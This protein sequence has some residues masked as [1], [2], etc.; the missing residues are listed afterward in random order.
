MTKPNVYIIEKGS[1]GAPEP[2]AELGEGAYSCVTT[3]GL[4]EY[5]KK[6]EKKFMLVDSGMASSFDKI[7]DEI[8]KHGKL[9]D[10]THILMTH[11]DQDH[12][13]NNN[14]FPGA[15]IISAV[16]TARSG[17]CTFGSIESLYPDNYIENENISYVD[18]SKTHSR[19]EM[20]YLVDSENIGLC[21]FVG[22]LMFASV[23]EM[24]GEVS[25]NFDKKVT[26]DIIRKYVILKEIYN[27]YP[28]VKNIFIGHSPNPMARDG[29]KKY[30][31][32]LEKE[33]YL[34]Y[35]KEFT[36]ELK[37]KASEYEKIVGKIQGS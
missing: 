7:K 17:T 8:E 15:V 14:K 28:Q 1:I 24:P 4:I 16:G 35:I 21:I 33:P 18:V 26:I 30:I 22:D 12:P 25:I 20:Y 11:F 36:E 5:E 37:E 10:V 32:M 13:Q 29:L 34:S 9:S 2:K 31:E 27:K 19:D 3:V 23:D 6:G